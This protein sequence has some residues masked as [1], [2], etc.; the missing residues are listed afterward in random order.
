MSIG[1]SLDGRQVEYMKNP[2]SNT[3]VKTN[4]HTDNVI[5]TT[6]EPQVATLA[7]ERILLGID[8]RCSAWF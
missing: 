4:T 3:E 5:T 2:N 1:K 7:H 8:Q 6:S